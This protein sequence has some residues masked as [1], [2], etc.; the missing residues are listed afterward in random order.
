[1]KANDRRLWDWFLIIVIILIGF[2]CLILA[3]SLALRFSPSWQL[4]ADMDSKLDPNSDFLTLRPGGFIEPVDSA[5]L[6]PPVWMNLFLTPGASF[7]TQQPN[8]ANTPAPY[9]PTIPSIPSTNTQAATASPTST[10][11]TLIYL[12]STPTSVSVPA[13]SR[14]PT[15]TLVNTYTPTST[16]TATNTP[17]PTF[18]PT[19]TYTATSTPTSTATATPTSTPASDADL[20]ITK[21]DNG[22][23]YVPGETLTYTVTISNNGPGVAIGAIMTD[24]IPAQIASWTWTCAAYG[25]GNGC[26][27]VSNSNASFADTV[28]LPS[29][30]GIVYTVTANV[31]FGA[32]GALTNSASISPPAGI[33]DSALF[34]NSAGDTDQILISSSFPNG[35]IGPTQ[36]GITDIL[37]PG[38]SI[39]LAFNTPLIAD[40]DS[41]YDLVYYELPNG[42]GIAMDYVIVQISDGYNWYTIFNWGDNNADTNSNLNLNVIG[43]IEN[44]NRDFTT[45]PASDILY[46]STGVLIDV[47]GIVPPGTYPYIRIISPSPD[48][49][50]GCEVD[51]IVTL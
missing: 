30:A 44:D 2:L 31:S 3:G 51:A 36:D 37:P 38:S 27:P 21:Y 28:N 24:N 8:N 26:D 46:N 16:Y 40:G 45:A 22:A 48:D 7:P 39:T 29:G 12:S 49:G 34:N 41:A 32:T 25:G 14:T 4:S 20:Q 50:D 17:T 35:N 5:I 13:G 11:T 6:T 23:L 47:D 15:A 1:M 42:T 9:N 33:T 18:T 43:G 10:K 19:S